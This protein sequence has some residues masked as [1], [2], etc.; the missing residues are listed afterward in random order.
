MSMSL[1]AYLLRPL[2]KEIEENRDIMRG[3]IPDNI[4]IRTKQTQ[5][6]AFRF[7]AIDFS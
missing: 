4:D 1:H 2:T 5:V 3:K 6:D 7:Y